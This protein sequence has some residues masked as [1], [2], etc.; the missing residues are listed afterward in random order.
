MIYRTPDRPT[1]LGCLTG[2]FSLAV[3]ALGVLCFFVAWKAAAPG[4]G[5]DSLILR[6]LLIG[7]IVATVAGL[8]GLIWSCRLLT[9]TIAKGS[10]PDDGRVY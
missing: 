6:K 4:S 2:L 1:P 10:P 3:L 8:A 9:N 7:G 5:V